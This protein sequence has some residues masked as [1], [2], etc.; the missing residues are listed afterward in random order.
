MSDTQRSGATLSR[1]EETNKVARES[2]AILLC[3]WH[4]P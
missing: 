2:C 3:V 4:G 1:S